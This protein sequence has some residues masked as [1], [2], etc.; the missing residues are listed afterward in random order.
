MSVDIEGKGDTV[1][2]HVDRVFGERADSAGLLVS[3]VGF[4]GSGKTTQLEALATHLRSEGR[5]VVETRQPSDWYRQQDIVN[6]FHF[7]GGRPDHAIYLRASASELAERLRLRD[8]DHLQFEERD[9][10]R[11]ESIIAT[12]ECLGPDLIRVNAS[13]PIEDATASILEATGL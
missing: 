6:T 10:R 5:E 4:D 8:G 12:Y 7:N 1:R 9:L 11:I 2:Q 13:D 3:V